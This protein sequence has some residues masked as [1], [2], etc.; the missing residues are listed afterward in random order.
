MKIT[1][2]FCATKA[3]KGKTNSQHKA[4]ANCILFTVHILTIKHILS[5]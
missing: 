3:D 4:I 1:L 2:G 5:F